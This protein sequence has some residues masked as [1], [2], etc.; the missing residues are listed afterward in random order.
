MNNNS[1]YTKGF[2][3]TALWKFL[4]K[5][6]RKNKK[7]HNFIYWVLWKLSCFYRYIYFYVRLLFKL[8][9]YPLVPL[10]GFIREHNLKKC[11]LFQSAQVKTPSPIFFPEKYQRKIISPHDQY[12]FP[13]V[14]ETLIAD[15]L[16]I[17]ASNLVIAN[18]EVVHH[19]LYHFSNDFTSEEM[20]CRSFVWPSRNRITWLDS[21]ETLEEI[22]EAAVFTD[23]CAMNYAHWMTEVLPR[24][25]IFCANEKNINIPIIVNDHLHSNILE[26][27]KIIAGTNRKIITIQKNQALLVHR[28]YVISVVGY[29]PFGRRTNRLKNSSHGLFSP[30]ALMSLKDRVIKYYEND[31]HANKNKFYIKRNSNLR[32]I[33]NQD[34]VEELLVKYGFSIVEPEKISFKDQ[35]EIFHNAE[36]I[37]GATGAAFGNIIFCQPTAKV[38][39]MISDY[40]YMPYWYWQNMACAVG[41]RVTYVIGRTNRFISHLHSDFIVNCED[42]ISAIK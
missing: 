36:V 15:G 21:F 17:G 29:V 13:D 9:R 26:S 5:Q 2:R 8:N 11:V 22:A 27:L 34:E 20:H 35:V 25:N 28:L 19:D 7:V 32:N 31:F 37:I 24:V 1:G 33:T 40:K 10:H 30:D 41:N 12:I 42:V 18:N 3:S 23:A 16:V 6:I 38:I 39:I 4:L 14:V